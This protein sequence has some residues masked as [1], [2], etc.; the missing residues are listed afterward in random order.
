MSKSRAKIKLPRASG[1]YEA[2]CETGQRYA[3]KLM[4]GLQSDGTAGSGA[5][6]S[7]ADASGIE[8][9]FWSMIEVAARCGLPRARAVADYW[10]ARK[11]AV[12]EPDNPPPK[13][14]SRARKPSK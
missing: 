9:G 13:R 10:A 7:P 11:S 3:L 2:D 12:Y 4:E 8:V 1:N 6:L 14:K 5:V